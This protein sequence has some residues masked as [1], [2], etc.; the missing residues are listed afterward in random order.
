[1]FSRRWDF[2]FQSA[3]GK[4]A[5][6]DEPSGRRSRPRWC[7]PTHLSAAHASLRVTGIRNRGGLTGFCRT[8][9][10]FFLVSNLLLLNQFPDLEADRSAGRRHLPIVLGRPSSSQVF[11]AFLA[12]AYV[13]LII[14]V[15]S[16]TLAPVVLLGLFTRP[17]CRVGLC[18]RQASR[19]RN[20]RAGEVHGLERGRDRGHPD[21]GRRGLAYWLRERSEALNG[22]GGG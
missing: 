2:P 17:A 16:G 7:Q 20:G 18:R 6:I 14:G 10:P 9:V 12:F 11:G 19:Q 5:S 8:L 21:T 4:F 13:S 1:M 22:R 15:T 3:P